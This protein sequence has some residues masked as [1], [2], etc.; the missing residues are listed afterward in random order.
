MKPIQDTASTLEELK[1]T[2]AAVCETQE[3]MWRAIDNMSKEVQELVQ[4]YVGTKG[5]EETKPV[6]TDSNLVEEKLALEAEPS[7]PPL[8]QIMKTSPFT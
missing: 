3:R 7:I 2:V 5:G 6:P 4:G 1:S 8:P